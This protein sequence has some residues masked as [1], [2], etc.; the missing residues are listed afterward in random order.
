MAA[1]KSSC[2]GRL[3]T[4]S[5]QY[6]SAPRRA[7]TSATPRGERTK[8]GRPAFA[9]AA[10]RCVAAHG[11][12]GGALDAG[13]EAR[14]VEHGPLRDGE[15]GGASRGGGQCAEQDQ[16]HTLPQEKPVAAANQLAHLGTDAVHQV[17]EQEGAEVV[18]C[19]HHREGG[20]QV[21]VLPP[22]KRRYH[23]GAW[24]L[25]GGTLR[26]MATPH[27]RARW[28]PRQDDTAASAAA[29]AGVAKLRKMAGSALARMAP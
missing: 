14:E 13:I 24:T 15:R 22:Q 20:Q 8:G 4:F 27:T 2:T 10:L 6:L 18:R 19:R 23:R 25:A 29:P 5:H 9:R 1:M 21:A 3:A 12:S 28:K 11:P 26:F 16:A 7:R 17:V